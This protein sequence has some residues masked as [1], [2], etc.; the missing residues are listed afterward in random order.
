MFL[1][2]SARGIIRIHSYAGNFCFQK[3]FTFIISHMDICTE[4]SNWF[5]VVTNWCN[6]SIRAHCSAT[7]VSRLLSV[8]HIDGLCGFHFSVE[9]EIENLVF[10]MSWNELFFPYQLPRIRIVGQFVN[11]PP[12]LLQ[13]Q[14]V[15][16]HF[17]IKTVH[18]K[19]REI[20]RQQ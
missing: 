14:I 17:P 10:E 9:V 13:E 1:S 20:Q 7:L 2:L 19:V 5:D 3:F 11:A 6:I 15:V 4:F 18:E 16:L 12:R 8:V